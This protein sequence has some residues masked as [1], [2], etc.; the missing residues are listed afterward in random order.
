MSKVIYVCPGTCKA[1]ISEEDYKQGL[2][3]CGADSCTLYK[4]PFIKM[5][6]CDDCGAVYLPD[7]IHQHTA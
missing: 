4:Q 6:K 2:I 7:D 5:L 1:S 3:Q